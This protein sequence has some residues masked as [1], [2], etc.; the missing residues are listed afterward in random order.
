MANRKEV[1]TGKINA[2]RSVGGANPKTALCI[3]LPPRG[4]SQQLPAEPQQS[5]GGRESDGGQDA[6]RDG[7]QVIPSHIEGLIT[8]L[9]DNYPV[10][11]TALKMCFST[12][13]H[14][15]NTLIANELLQ[16]KLD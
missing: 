12:S 15:K 11:T 16:E 1:K 14:P 8:R 9:P 4:Q 6:G 3:A 5:G 13:P 2:T 10:T 7:F